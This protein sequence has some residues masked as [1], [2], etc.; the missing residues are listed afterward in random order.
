MAFRLAGPGWEVPHLDAQAAGV[1]QA[2]KLG[3][4]EPAAGIVQA[5]AVQQLGDRMAF[6]LQRLRQLARALVGPAQR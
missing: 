1:R 2:L 5:E 3:A 6:G 4:P